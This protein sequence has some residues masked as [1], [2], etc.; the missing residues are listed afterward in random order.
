MTTQRLIRISAVL[1]V[2]GVL[3]FTMAACQ[4]PASRG[5]ETATPI[6]GNFPIPGATDTSGGGID[7]GALSTQT[8]QAL[9]TP[10]V[11]SIETQLAQPAVT[12]TPVAPVPGGSS[13]VPGAGSPPAEPVNYVVATPGRPNT[14]ELQPGEFIYCIAR[15]FDVNPVDLLV[16]NGLGGDPFLQPGYVLS[17]PQSGSFPGERSLIDHPAT[18]TVA[19]G[20]TIF[21]IACAF[22]DVSPDMIALQNHLSWPVNFSAGDV[23][24]I[25]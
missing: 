8:A 18:Y 22:G 24:I 25:P 14:Y 2:V 12:E 20:E 21:S 13:P 16:L 10:P 19:A 7:V 9:I 4:M 5:P 6:G 3:A 23:I 11:I 17:I 15:R 1:L